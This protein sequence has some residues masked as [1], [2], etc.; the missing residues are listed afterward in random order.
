[1]NF[2]D[3]TTG[4]PLATPCAQGDGELWFSNDPLEQRIAKRLCGTCPIAAQK[5]CLSL[6]LDHETNHG[7]GYRH[8]IW[9][10]KT[11]AERSRLADRKAVA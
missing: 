7:H 8:G 5:A 4:D 10:G 9:A 1:M 3:K 6:A 11:P 2:I